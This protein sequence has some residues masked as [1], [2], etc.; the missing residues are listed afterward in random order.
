MRNQKRNCWSPIVQHRSV[1]CRGMSDRM[2]E[3]GSGS[4]RLSRS[5]Q[6]DQS[7]RLPGTGGSRQRW[8]PTR[9]LGSLILVVAITLVGSAVVTP[10]IAKD[11]P[12]NNLDPV[13]ALDLVS[14]DVAFCLEIPNLE[15][16]WP[17]LEASQLM[18]RL[19]QF[20]PSQHF[21]DSSGVKRWRSLED[22][23]AQVTQLNLSEQL[24]LLFAK[25]LVLA[26][27][28][29]AE[30]EPRGILIGRADS[31]E[32]VTTA[33]ATWTALEPDPVIIPKKHHTV[34][35][36]QRKKSPTS[37]DS[38]F[39]TSY[40]G[41]FAISDHEPLVQ[42]VIERFRAATGREPPTVLA[43]SLRRSAFFQRSRDRLKKT[44][45][46]AFLHIGAR[47]WDRGVQEVSAGTDLSIDPAAVWKHVTSVSACVRFD[48]GLVCETVID[49]D[50]S[51]M[52]SEWS[53]LVA[54]VPGEPAWNRRVPAE[55][56]LAVG[57]HLELA[58]IIRF[59]LKQIDPRQRPIEVA[60]NQADDQCRL[61]RKELFEAV[62]P[63]LARNFCGFV[64][65]REDPQEKRVT[66]DGLLGFTLKTANDEQVVKDFNQGFE[67]ALTSFAEQFSSK[68]RDKISV[69]H[70]ATNDFQSYW[71][72]GP[73][74]IP[75]AFGLKGK[76]LHVTGSRER[77]LRSFEMAKANENP[78]R[79][80]EHSRR[81]FPDA[82][83]LV[84]FDAV[85]IR[86]LLKTKGCDVVKLLSQGSEE[87]AERLESRYEQ[88]RPV[89]ELLDSFFVAGQLQS[90]YIRLTFGGGLDAK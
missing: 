25:S 12:V 63:G 68:V 17:K 34:K 57:G 60:Q 40:Q 1:E 56:L 87:E 90:D 83:Q 53:K 45:A 51:T 71:L 58:P 86:R 49:L 20:P 18:D 21:F 3:N 82:E 23:I 22:K 29:P 27:Y 89:L 42:D 5:V 13:A 77:L 61:I 44:G 65:P 16:T 37:P 70:E 67:C 11:E 79:L 78:T 80:A 52:P 62:L 59:G 64:V 73:A 24:R 76:E 36:I 41:W 46:V 50:R 4:V 15:E 2:P 35:Y 7:D 28:V 48:Q 38:L 26:M 30:G 84:W 32:T 19:R 9:F 55:A 33:V 31:K 74:P 39:F 6:V 72:S 8:F 10:V 85:Q 54:T 14:N 81:Y 75:L 88:F 66:L 43:T 69:N 47:P